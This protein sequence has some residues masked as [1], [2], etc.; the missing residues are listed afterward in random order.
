MQTFQS[1]GEKDIS[2]LLT[3]QV[4]FPVLPHYFGEANVPGFGI[5]CT[6]K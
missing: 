5:F 3:S 1:V 6:D 4:H 2:K